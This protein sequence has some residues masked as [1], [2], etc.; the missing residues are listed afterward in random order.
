MKLRNQEL[1]S[2]DKLLSGLY[3][4]VWRYILLTLPR[5][6]DMRI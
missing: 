2:P 5:Y 6:Q 4:L 3:G 1:I